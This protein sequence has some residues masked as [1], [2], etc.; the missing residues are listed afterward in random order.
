MQIE[1][2]IS[3]I[4]PVYNGINYIDNCVNSLINQKCN[5][6]YEIILID[7][8]SKDDSLNRIKDYSNEY[9]NIHYYNQSNK[10]ASSARNVGLKNARGEY[11]V[12]VDIDDVVTDEY[13]QNLCKNHDKFKG[14]GLVVSG[15]IA[16]GEIV[17][18]YNGEFYKNHQY[19]SML[20]EMDIL[21]NGYTVGKLYNLDLIRK[22]DILFDEKVRY[23]EDLIFYLQ[24]LLF[25]DWVFFE[26]SYDYIYS[27]NNPNSLILSYSP[28]V[29]EMRGFIRVNELIQL[30]VK[31][32]PKYINRIEK[33]Y[34]WVAHFAARAIISIYWGNNQIISDKRERITLI[35]SSFVDYDLFLMH[36]YSSIIE[37]K[38]QIIIWLLYTGRYSSLDLFVNYYFKIRYSKFFAFLYMKF[39]KIIG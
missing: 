39:K 23:A 27:V 22:H 5:Y 29:N 7:D 2:M 26:D 20:D 24:Y 32:Y 33:C 11:V 14:T 4:V 28:F 8:G 16:K 19:A 31:K 25:S 17:K 36:K 3:V 30:Y 1:P 18:K 15:L 10:G 34:G 12:F 13:L 21:K 37:L 9:E 38:E 6:N 35:E